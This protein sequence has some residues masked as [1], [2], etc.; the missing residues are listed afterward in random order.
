[1]PSTDAQSRPHDAARAAVADTVPGL[2]PRLAAIARWL[3]PSHHFNLRISLALRM[4]TR[5]VAITTSF[6]EGCT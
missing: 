5:S 1:M 3:S 2:T 4:D 6:R